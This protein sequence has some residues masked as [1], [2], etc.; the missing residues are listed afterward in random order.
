[1]AQASLMSRD[2]CWASLTTEWAPWSE[3]CCVSFHFRDKTFCEPMDGSFHRSTLAHREGLIPAC[4]VPG[5]VFIFLSDENTSGTA[6][7]S[8]QEVTPCSKIH[9]LCRQHRP[10]SDEDVVGSSA[11]CLSSLLVCYCLKCL[12]DAALSLI[13]CARTSLL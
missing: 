11:L 8:S 4:Q 7:L 1:M 9:L 13:Y 12:Q 5:K 10:N 2:L 6:W 3:P